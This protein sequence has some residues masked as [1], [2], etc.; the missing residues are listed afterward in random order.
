MEVN[1]LF[2]VLE[3]ERLRLREINMEDAEAL[4]N[5][6]SSDKV[7]RYYGQETF[8]KI[9]EAEQFVKAFRDTYEKKRGIRWGIERKSNPGLIGTIGLHAWASKHRRAE[10]GY[11]LHPDHWRN[12][13]ISEALQA[14]VSY[15]FNDLNLTRIGAIVFTE[16][17]GSQKLLQKLGFQQEGMLKQYMYQNGCSFDVNVYALLRDELNDADK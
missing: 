9:D 10:V 3:T 4:F 5:C 12:G 17:E 6:F 15:G 1:G 11:E 8:R 14:V 7:T 16:N 13:Y 2:P